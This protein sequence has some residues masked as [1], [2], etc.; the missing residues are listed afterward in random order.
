MTGYKPA[1]DGVC[2]CLTICYGYRAKS[3]HL[4]MGRPPAAEK[5]TSPLARDVKIAVLEIRPIRAARLFDLRL[6]VDGNLPDDHERFV[7]FGRSLLPFPLEILL[8]SSD[9]GVHALL[10]LGRNDLDNRWE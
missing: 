5:R 7:G 3:I 2:D 8:G 10:K 9:S 1:P 6:L 4:R